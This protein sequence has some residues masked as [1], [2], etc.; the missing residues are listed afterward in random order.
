MVVSR[1]PET[2]PEWWEKHNYL[3]G[4]EI[5]EG[6]WLCLAPMIYTFRVM[7]CDPWGAMEFYCYDNLIDAAAAFH[8]WDGQGEI[9]MPG[10]TKHHGSPAGRRKAIAS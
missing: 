3:A 9:P 6:S 7:V 8:M 4:K 2:T 5:G 10:W 1:E